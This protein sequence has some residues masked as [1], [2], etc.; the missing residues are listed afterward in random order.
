MLSTDEDGDSAPSPAMAAADEDADVTRGFEEQELLQ[1]LSEAV[2]SLPERERAVCCRS[3]MSSGFTVKEI[4]VTLSVSET[5]VSQL[6]A[7]AVRRLR[8]SLIA[9]DAA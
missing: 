7:Q 4:A 5:R 9:S 8:N 2:R 6:H 3:S 1:S